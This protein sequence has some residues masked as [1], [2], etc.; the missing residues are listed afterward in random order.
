MGE[1]VSGCARLAWCV[2]ACARAFCARMIGPVG[3]CA[4]ARVAVIHPVEG[5]KADC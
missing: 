1:W 4:G 2:Y 3:E 5:R